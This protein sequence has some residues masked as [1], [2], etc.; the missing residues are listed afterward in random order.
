MYMDKV[1]IYI[2]ELCFSKDFYRLKFG[3]NSFEGWKERFVK[4]IQYLKQYNFS[5]FDLYGIVV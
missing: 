5:D 3:W 1:Y 2:V 4:F